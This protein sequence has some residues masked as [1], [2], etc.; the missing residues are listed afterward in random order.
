MVT[1]AADDLL[2]TTEHD[3]SVAA[4]SKD[5]AAEPADGSPL[6]GRGTVACVQGEPTESKGTE[7]ECASGSLSASSYEIESVLSGSGT[8]VV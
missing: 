2:R 7:S 5:V 1:H 8:G 4:P 3:P 6:V